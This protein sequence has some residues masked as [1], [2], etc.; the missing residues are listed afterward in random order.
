MVNDLCDF[1]VVT[2]R[3]LQDTFHLMPAEHGALSWRVCEKC[4]KFRIFCGD[5][6]F[7]ESSV[8]DRVQHSADIPGLIAACDKAM[9][10]VVSVLGSSS[11]DKNDG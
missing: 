6:P 10:S 8:R 9:E 7:A 4:N 5:K 1:A 11:Q 3:D 2:E